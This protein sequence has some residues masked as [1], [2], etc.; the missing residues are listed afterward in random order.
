MW[1]LLQRGGDRLGPIIQS[2]TFLM[3]DCSPRWADLKV[4]VTATWCKPSRSE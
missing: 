3:G 1:T 4:M 2:T